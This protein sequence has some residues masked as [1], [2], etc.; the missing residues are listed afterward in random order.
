MK[1]KSRN[2]RTTVTHHVTFSLLVFYIIAHTHTKK[3]KKR[4]ELSKTYATADCESAFT[5]FPFP[6]RYR[7]LI[8]VQSS[9]GPCLVESICLFRLV[10][11]KEK[12][13]EMPYVVNR[14]PVC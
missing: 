11:L 9:N 13:H 1:R 5:S 6:F 7:Y 2:I 12:S 8:H 4:V 3:K 10:F 14:V